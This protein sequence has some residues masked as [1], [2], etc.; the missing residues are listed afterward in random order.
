MNQRLFFSLLVF[1]VAT[2]CY[3]ESSHAQSRIGVGV[4]VLTKSDVNGIS[5]RYRNFQAIVGASFGRSDDPENQ[6]NVHS[7][8]LAA[9]YNHPVYDWKRL[10][11]KVFGQVDRYELKPEASTVPPL[12]R[13]TSGGSAE[14]QVTG[15]SSPSKGLFL[16]VDV[17]LSIARQG[18]EIGTVPSRGVGIHVIF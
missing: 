4:V 2:T 6:L 10:N 1:V 18:D 15:R 3:V 14:L 13:L 7:L 9:R 12:Y 8:S 11:F 5:I 16:T 17:G